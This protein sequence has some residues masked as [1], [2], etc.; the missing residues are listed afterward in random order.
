MFVPN[1]KLIDYLYETKFYDEACLLINFIIKNR[2]SF[3][4]TFI[5]KTL[6]LVDKVNYVIGENEIK[7]LVSLLDFKTFDEL[8]NILIVLI[9]HNY[10]NLAQQKFKK[11]INENNILEEEIMKT[12]LVCNKIGL[13]K[14][15]IDLSTDNFI[16][17]HL[18]QHFI[19]IKENIQTISE[20]KENINTDEFLIEIIIY[21]NNLFK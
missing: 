7:S 9:Y 18:Q 14:N 11:F 10:D 4:Y 20:F 15:E 6:V 16:I 1:I 21:L 8:F 13:F 3:N 12:L 2:F 17:K 19:F 5:Y